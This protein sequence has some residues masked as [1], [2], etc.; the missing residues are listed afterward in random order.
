MPSFEKPQK[1]NPH[2]LTISQHIFPAK[3]IARFASSDGK[4]QLQMLRP[5]LV[6]QAKPSDSIFCAQRV[7]DHG[8][9][10]G[11]I[12]ALEDRFQRL[13]TLIID[14]HVMSFDQEQTYVISSFFVLWRVRAELRERPTQ[15]TVLQGVLPGRNRSK[16]E[17]ERLEK[18]GL[19]FQRG[20]TIP[21]HLVNGLH[22]RILVSRYLRQM[23]PTA[24]WG[25]VRASGGEFVVPDWPAYAFLPIN[26][27]LALANPAFNQILQRDTI[28]LVNA[29]MRSAS[30]RYFIARDFAECP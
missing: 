3:S 7:W 12:K 15:N 9:E 21:A 24:T 11:F 25:I 16:D 18:A 1:G 6:R 14:G 2:C 20:I 26:P 17:E 28:G 5:S 29:Q 30:Q 8:S 23:N 10:V 13:A 19:A 27:T 22:V 4:V